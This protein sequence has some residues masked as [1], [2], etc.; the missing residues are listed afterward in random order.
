MGP[1]RPSYQV[2]GGPRSTK[3]HYRSGLSTLSDPSMRR[4][5]ADREEKHEPERGMVSEARW[6]ELTDWGLPNREG[7]K[8]DSV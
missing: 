1:A 8:P 6:S 3:S 7:D 2:T 4:L 5:D